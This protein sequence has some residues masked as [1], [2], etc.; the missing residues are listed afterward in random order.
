MIS[1]SENLRQLDVSAALSLRL[2]RIVTGEYDHQQAFS[3]PTRLPH[4]GYTGQRSPSAHCLP[5][6]N[7]N[8][9]SGRSITAFKADLAS[10]AFGKRTYL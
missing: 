7:V 5:V 4:S 6:L 3:E 2:E 10:S 1:Y 9:E 8:G